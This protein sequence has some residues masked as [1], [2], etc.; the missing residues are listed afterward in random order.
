[1]KKYIKILFLSMVMVF[2]ARQGLI[3][4][5]Q[6]GIIRNNAESLRLNFQIGQRP[7]YT[8]TKAIAFAQLGYFL[9]LNS[10]A[11]WQT[12]DNSIE[13]ETD[14]IRFLNSSSQNSSWLNFIIVK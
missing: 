11:F 12:L 2:A 7:N 4:K 5:S 8:R 13:V 1:M 3:A 10:K 9:T 6:S 14:L